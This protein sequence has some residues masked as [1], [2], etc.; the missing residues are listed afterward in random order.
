MANALSRRSV[1]PM[2]ARS[3][4]ASISLLGLLA[5]L[6]LA[7]AQGLA[8]EGLPASWTERIDRAIEAAD[9]A[10]TDPGSA[11][12]LRPE[13][14]P[15]P[16]QGVGEIDLEALAEQYAE[17]G[18]PVPSEQPTLFAAISFSMPEPSLR[19]LIDDAHRTGVTLVM[20]GL[21]NNSLRE[22]MGKAA[23]LIGERQVAWTIDPE[24][25][26]RFGIGA[27]P[28]YVLIPAGVSARECGAGQC[29]SED[30]FVRISGDVPVDYVLDRIEQSA[31][32]FAPTVRLFRRTP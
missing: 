28:S 9:R 24:V 20:R 18:K 25:F 30:S 10:A 19:R 7:S 27:V 4:L 1:R 17:V 13:N 5:A 2:P 31:P 23:Q 11:P 16:V 8:E 26:T 32:Q 3:R 29:F 14:L 15:R 22:T 12:V 21:Y 6:L